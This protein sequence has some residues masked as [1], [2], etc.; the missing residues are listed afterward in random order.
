[1]LWGCQIWA[2][3]GSEESHYR[4]VDACDLG[5]GRHP[6]NCQS[7]LSLLFCHL[8][9]TILMIQT[10]AHVPFQIMATSFLVCL[11]TV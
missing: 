8:V 7:R 9:V 1:M 4:K 3:R 11:S 6:S 5:P 2:E 10:L